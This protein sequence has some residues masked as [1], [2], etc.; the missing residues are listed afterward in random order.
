MQH[1]LN[2]F[3][4]SNELEKRA[5]ADSLCRA[6]YDLVQIESIDKFMNCTT[7]DDDNHTV[8]ETVTLPFDRP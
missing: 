8:L 3:E 1:Q 4:G 7:I 6:R 5:H 2:L